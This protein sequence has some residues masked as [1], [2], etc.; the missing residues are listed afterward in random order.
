MRARQ[1]SIQLWKRWMQRR[2]VIIARVSSEGWG[3]GERSVEEWWRVRGMQRNWNTT[4]FFS[5][6]SSILLTFSSVSSICLWWLSFWSIADSW[7]ATPKC[8]TQ[9]KYMPYMI[10]R[11]VGTPIDWFGWYIDWLIWLI[12][13]LI[14]CLINCL[15][16]WLTDCL[17]ACLIDWLVDWL[18]YLSI[19]CCLIDWLFDS[20]CIHAFTQCNHL[21]NHPFIQS[22]NH[23]F[24]HSVRKTFWSTFVHREIF[25]VIYTI[26]CLTKMLARGFI[27]ADFT[28]LRD[29]WNWLD[30]VVV[31][32]A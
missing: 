19:A 1:K 14:A 26:E 23:S 28:F 10:Y 31:T 21:S 29:S 27:L 6:S 7:Q 12:Y 25:T 4:R 18:T 32:L 17:F 9:S 13:Q 22:V 16:N 30:F 5:L 20:S 2:A 3:Q 8:H 24:C 11:L 15:I